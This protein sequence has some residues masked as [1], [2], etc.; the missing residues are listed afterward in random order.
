MQKNYADLVQRVKS[1]SNPDSIRETELFSK[2]FNEDFRG[3]G[4]PYTEVFEYVKRAMQGVESEYTERT[5]EAGNKIKEHLKRNNS[6]LD[7]KFQGS[8]MC[9]T[10]IKG[11][12][13]ID[14]VQI[15]NSF[16]SHEPIVKFNEKFTSSSYLTLSQKQNLLSVI[17]GTPYKD[18]VRDNLR[19][20]RLEAETV[21]T[22]TYKYVDITKSK[23]I[24][25][26]PTNPDRLVD[27]VTASWYKNVDSVLDNDVDKNGIQI[28]DKEKNLRLPV[29]FPFLKIQLLNE[30][31]KS[32]NGRLKKMI[33]FLKTIKA[34]SEYNLN[35]I[36]SF[37]ISSIC[38]NI[39][40][41]K[42]SDKPYY[43]LVIVLYSEL[44]KIIEDENYRNSIRS[45]DNTEYIFKD[46]NEKVRLLRLIFNELLPI[47]QD[48]SPQT[49]FTKFL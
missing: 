40:T 1:R 19:K 32:V 6:S 15:T 18:D 34:D 9:N 33:R 36:S 20:I 8:V 42:Y 21:L 25:V 11:H 44:K 12:S 48:L 10:H 29:D 2:S 43:E 5:I 17:N 3:L 13:D 27:V 35:E 41:W 30:K 16:Y 37:D 47:Y 38:Y 14:L 46:K 28:Y 31:D 23:S 39:P 26:N 22:S 4:I 7:Y 24:E 45:I 49:S